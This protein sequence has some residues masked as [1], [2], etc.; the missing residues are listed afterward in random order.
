MELYH[1]DI[2][3]PE[4][5]RLP[6]RVVN[7]HWTRH[8]DTARLNDRYGEIPR[9][10]LVNLGLC[11]VV[12]VGLTGRKVEKVIVRTALDTY[13]DIVLALIPMAG[14]W[15]VKTVWINQANDSHNTLDRSRY[16]C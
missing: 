4:G 11:N 6:N 10:P 9:I 13:N 16:V 5:F 12:E 1:A 3:L 7:L 15:I 14:A 2:R 8:A